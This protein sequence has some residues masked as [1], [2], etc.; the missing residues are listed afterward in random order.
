MASP[1]RFPFTRLREAFEMYPNADEVRFVQDEPA[2]QGPW[3]FLALQ[4]PEYLPDMPKLTR[5]SRRAQSSTAT[6]VAKVHAVEQK[7]LLEEAFK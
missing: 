3:P 6:G 4:L 5:V 7:A 1:R 2:N